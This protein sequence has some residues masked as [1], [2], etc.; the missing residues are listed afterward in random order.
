MTSV[1]WLAAAWVMALLRGSHGA[2]VA[3]LLAACVAGTTFPDLDFNLLL[4]HRSAVTHSVLVPLLLLAWTRARAIAP[5]L[6]MGMGFHLAADCFPN[7]M[8]GYATVKL[9]LFGSIGADASY[10]WLGANA[11]V[12]FAAGLAL[13][14]RSLPRGWRVAALAGYASIGTSYLF[15]TDGGWPALAIFAAAGWL[16]VRRRKAAR[17]A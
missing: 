1:I 2:R 3:A 10:L 16:A 4:T 5:G 9:P 12:A 17:T 14:D 7:A 15:V 8:R 11:L 13:L 6:T